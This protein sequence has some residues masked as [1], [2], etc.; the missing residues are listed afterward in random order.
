MAH[1]APGEPRCP[2]REV[3]DL[4]LLCM[5]RLHHCRIWR[6]LGNGPRRADL[7]HLHDVL[8]RLRLRPHPGRAAGDLQR[9]QHS[10][11]GAGGQDGVSGGL[12][13]GAQGAQARGAAHQ[14]LDSVPVSSAAL[15]PAEPG[16]HGQPAPHPASGSGVHHESQ[17]FLEGAHF[18]QNS[19]QR[20]SQGHLHGRVAGADVV[21]LLPGGL[22]G[23]LLGTARRPHP[24][25]RL[26]QRGHLRS[27]ALDG[28]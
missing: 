7:L 26:G 10:D 27:G 14:K 20:Q 25:H 8:R 19:Q 15:G 24:C 21:Q 3:R 5:H 18:G 4:L 6:Y 23:R 2:E 17:P 16:D 9:I 12:P 13:R 22:P 11:A 28:P 1:G